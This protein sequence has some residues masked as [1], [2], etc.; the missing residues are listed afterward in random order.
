M[1]LIGWDA[2][3]NCGNECAGWRSLKSSFFAGRLCLHLDVTT[4]KK[5]LQRLRRAWSVTLLAEER[6][7]GGVSKS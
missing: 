7:V 6:L 2:A 4:S 1:T 3:L 5:K